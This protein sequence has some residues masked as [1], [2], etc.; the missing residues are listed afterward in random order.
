M[1]QDELKR[2]RSDLRANPDLKDEIKS[3]KKKASRAALITWA[4]TKGYTIDDGDFNS[5]SS[6]QE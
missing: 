2:L 6:S 1:S 3:L 5:A 4:E